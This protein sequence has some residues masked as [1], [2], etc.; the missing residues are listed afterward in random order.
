MLKVTSILAY[1]GMAGAILALIAMKL[2]FSPHPLVI[3]VQIGALALMV[4]ARVVFGIRSFHA[5]A[6]PTKGGLVTS[7]PYRYIRHPIYTAACLLGWAGA[8]AHFSA[9]ALL[10]GVVLIVC[11]VVRMQCEERLVAATYPEYVHY[12]DRTW[13][14]IPYVY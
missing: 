3:G 9:K 6:T 1:A 4:W 8:L 5:A 14:M 13:R 12:K 10:C 7:G 2:F 11:A